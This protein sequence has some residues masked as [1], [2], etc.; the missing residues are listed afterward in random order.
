MLKKGRGPQKP[1]DKRLGA[2]TIGYKSGT[3]QL[4]IGWALWRG[5]VGGVGMRA[6]CWFV[7]LWRCPL[8]SCHC[9]LTLC[10][11]KRVFVVSTEG[12]GVPPPPSN[13]SLG[14][15]Q[16]GIFGGYEIVQSGTFFR[17]CLGP[18]LRTLRPPPP[19]SPSGSS[20]AGGGGGCVQ[21][22]ECLG[23]YGHG[24]AT[25]AMLL[26]S[27]PPSRQSQ[28]KGICFNWGAGGR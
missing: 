7:C 8:A 5:G 3:Q 20:K 10:G 16:G 24:T 26:P 2:V 6:W 28:D 13:P 14:E 19:S 9:T 15:V 12:G 23:M 21:I 22:V 1:L 17:P 25:G 18:K 11:S 4:G 27:S